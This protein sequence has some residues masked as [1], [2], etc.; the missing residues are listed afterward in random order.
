M[1]N[2][3][4]IMLVGHYVEFFFK[5]ICMYLERVY[6][7][8]EVKLISLKSYKF[9]LPVKKILTDK[10]QKKNGYLYVKNVHVHVFI[11]IADINLS[12]TYVCGFKN[13]KSQY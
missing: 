10:I 4:N 1:I 11:H 9:I 8:K 2:E 5:F 7:L 12:H 6:E 13:Q 3:N